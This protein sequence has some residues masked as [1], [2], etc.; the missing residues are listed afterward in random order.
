[1]PRR[2]RIVLVALLAIAT[3]VVAALARL[4]WV[5]GMFIRITPH[6]DGHCRLVTGPVGPED[7]TIDAPARRAIISAYDRRAARS[8][9]PVPGGIW[10][11]S[12]DAVDAVPVNLTPDAGLYLQPHGI[13]LW[14]EP[15]GREVL[16]AVNHP[17]PG[18]GWP[19]HTIEIYDLAGD[20]LTHRATLTD[21]RLVMPNDLVAVGV[22]RFYVTNTHAYGRG[23]MQ[24]IETYLRLRGAQVLRYG[25]GGF[26]TAIA[27]LVFPNGINVS[28]DGRTIYVAAVTDRSVLV[29]D[30]DPATDALTPRG[31]I[32]IHSGG[33]NIEID[34]EGQLWIGAHPKLLAM[35]RHATD[36]SVPAPAQVLRVSADGRTVDEIYLNDGTPIAA[37]S[38][39]ARFANRL[40]IGQIFSD[41]FLDCE[42]TGGGG[43]AR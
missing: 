11:Y 16:F 38:V 18:H 19:E 43:R 3:L 8:G 31:E 4:A 26:T 27:K 24:V 34:D 22:D 32:P 33:D 29:Y 21:P 39:G 14:R 15:D 9:R 28:R 12:L 7:L 36:P 17:A 10:S 6:F 42:M 2:R 13:S 41:G 25:P 35:S 30:R 5:G 1:M 20:T 23:R 37:S 40:L